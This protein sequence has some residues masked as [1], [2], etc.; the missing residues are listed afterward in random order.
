MPY[1][2]IK[3]PMKPMTQSILIL[4]NDEALCDELAAILADAGY[5]VGF[6]L[7]GQ[8]GRTLLAERDFDLVLLGL[9]LSEDEKFELTRTFI[10]AARERGCETRVLI[11]SEEGLARTGVSQGDGVLGKPPV[12]SE[13]LEKVQSLIGKGSKPGSRRR[14]ALAHG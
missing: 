9:E 6:G 1:N 14:R 13:L 2:H 5:A 10:G 7:N 8:E 11:L 12:I 3:H 4:D